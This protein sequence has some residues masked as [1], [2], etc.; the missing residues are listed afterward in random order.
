MSTGLIMSQNIRKANKQ[1]KLSPRLPCLPLI[2]DFCIFFALHVSY[3][4]SNYSTAS[5]AVALACTHAG[6]DHMDTN[7][8][9]SF[10]PLLVHHTRTL[11]HTHAYRTL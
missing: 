7:P 8:L 4:F 3:K 6:T 11:T 5:A 2:F 9:L 1:R 10:Y